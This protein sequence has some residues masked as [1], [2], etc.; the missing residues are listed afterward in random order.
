MNAHTYKMVLDPPPAVAWADY[1]GIAASEIAKA[2]EFDAS[3][4]ELH[5]LF[6]RHPCL[7]PG[8]RGM[9]LN[10]A[11]SAFPAAV[12]SKPPVPSWGGKI[13]DFMW[14][15]SDSLTLAPVFIEIESP[16][17]PWFTKAGQQTHELTQALNQLVD[18]RLWF[19]DSHHKE[20]FLDFYHLDGMLRYRLFQPEFI[21]IYG[22]RADSHRSEALAKKRGL[23]QTV[24]QAVVSYDRLFPSEAGSDYMC[25]AIDRNG[26]KALAVPPTITL[27]PLW[28]KER[29]LVARKREAIQA[30]AYIPQPRKAFLKERVPYWD[31]WAQL[32][33]KGPYN[34]GDWE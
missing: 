27:G 17:K 33:K 15:A 1:K 5:A 26:Y 11:E 23:L 28:A 21:L 8:R 7:L 12:I 18:W 10:G 19:E 25:V 2:L 29:A 31:E 34:L 20:A 16:G 6:E 9:P 24:N 4:A 14:I 3:E 13:P 30:N 32:A 22:R